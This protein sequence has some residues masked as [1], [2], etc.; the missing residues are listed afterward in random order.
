VTHAIH[1][2]CR[3][4]SRWFW[5]AAL[6]EYGDDAHKC[7]DPV[8]IYGGPHEYGWEDTEE[9]ALKAMTEAA[10]R[11]GEEFPPG[12]WKGARDAS[13]ALKRINAAKRRARPPKRG[14]SEAAPVEYLYEPWSWTDYDNYP[15]ETQKGINEI[16]IAKKTA[17]RIYYDRTSRWDREDGVVTLGYIDRQDFE[18]DTRC[19]DVC[20]RDIPAGLVC[21]PHGRDFPHCIHF[22]ERDYRD[23]RHFDPR[24]CG[25][26]CPVDTQGMECAEHGYAWDHCPHRNTPGQCDRGFPAGAADLGG[27]WYRRGGTV[28]A[29]REAAG[30]YL[31]RWEREQEHKRK[32]AG[33]ELRRLRMAMAD[34]HPDR[35]GTNEGFIAAR[36]AYK[37]AMRRAS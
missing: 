27:P 7:D 16:P 15:Y 19:R 1:G 24:G 8:C 10:A 5:I 29:T 21:G 12:S 36:E 3:S 31:H 18:T 13:A 9:L 30:D 32:E 4:G 33:P 22:G 28:F 35:G 20:R 14:I 26:I 11:L 17:K 25:E 23:P 37:Q 34:A 2:R 6:M